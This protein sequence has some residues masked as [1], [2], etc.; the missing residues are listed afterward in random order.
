MVWKKMTDIN[1]SKLSWSDLV[2]LK[3]EAE[4]EI[5]Y[6]LVIKHTGATYT[7]KHVGKRK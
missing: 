5:L 3:Q 6:R 7:E 1:V 4:R 2:Y